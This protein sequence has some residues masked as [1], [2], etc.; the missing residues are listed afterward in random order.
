MWLAIETA[1]A[2]CSVALIDEDHVVAR[3]HEL[4]GRGHAERLLPMIAEVMAD[5]RAARADAIVVD[6][7][8]GSFT[9]IRIGVAAARAL[10]LA[11]SVPVTGFAADTLVAAA[12]FARAPDL[13]SLLVVLDGGRGEVFARLH[14]REGPEGAAVAL[15]PQAAAA[16][17][18]RVGSAAGNGLTPL[19]EAPGWSCALGPDAAMAAL[20]PAAARA[21]PPTPCY[22]RAP[23][24]RPVP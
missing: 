12:A 8:P 24:A 5:A 19:G 2:A 3:R 14:R 16:W 1:H 18:A 9:G 4:V 6:I 13:G 11:W 15:A 22:V 20:L 21:L 23:D 7:G 17:R 10:G